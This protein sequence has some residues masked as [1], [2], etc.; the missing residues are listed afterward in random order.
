MICAV[1]ACLEQALARMVVLSDDTGQRLPNRTEYCPE[2]AEQ[3]ADLMRR[4]MIRVRLIEI[5][6]A[7]P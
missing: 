3:V 7:A 6:T 2:H 4:R 1:H 5:S